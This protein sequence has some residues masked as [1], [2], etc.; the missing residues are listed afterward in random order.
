[1]SKKQE[2][3]LEDYASNEDHTEIVYKPDVDVLLQKEVSEAIGMPGFRMGAVTAMY[4]LSNSGKTTIMLH[5]AIQAQKQGIIPVFVITE[6]KMDWS[7]AEKMGLDISKSKCIIREDLEYLEDVYNYISQK[8]EDVKTG[9]LPRD[10]MIFWD[11]VASTPSIESLEIDKSGKIKKKYGPQKNASVIGYYNPIIMKRIASTRQS[12]S[13]NTVGLVMLTQAYVKPPEFPGGMAT[14]IPNG[15]EKIWF[16]LSLC[17]QI[18]EGGE[19]SAK[20]DGRKVVFGTVCR[21]KVAKN[22]LTSTSTEGEFVITADSI[23]P[24]TPEAIEA[25]KKANKDSWGTFS[26]DDGEELEE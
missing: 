22:H 7:R 6:N 9:R 3:S 25:Y 12:D 16:P 14:I 10:I 11:S 4:G 23:L 26:T 13:P 2:F 24:N 20:V 1:M 21:I 17:L 8:I 18:K 5:A 19:L 15:G